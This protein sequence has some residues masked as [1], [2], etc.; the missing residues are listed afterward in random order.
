MPITIDPEFIQLLPM[1]T[2]EELETLEKSLL[3]EG[4]RDP[5]I[6]TSQGTVIDG[7]TRFV[8]C[9]KRGIPFETVV[10]DFLNRKA[11]RLWIL[12]NQ[13]GRRNLT[14]AQRISIA[15][16]YLSEGTCAPGVKEVAQKA[17][18]SER[19][20]KNF[21]KA[22]ASPVKELGRMMKDG[23]VAIRTAAEVASLPRQKQE[24]I[25]I[26]G[27]SAVKAAAAKVREGKV[28]PPSADSPYPDSS[29]VDEAISAVAKLKS[30][31]TQLLGD[32]GNDREGEQCG[33]H[34]RN[35]RQEWPK[36]LDA[37]RFVLKHYRPYAVCPYCE[38]KAKGCD[39]CKNIGWVGQS[40]FER[41]PKDYQERTKASIEK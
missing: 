25:I 19:T 35:N 1:S 12:E 4:C 8:I 10:K 20:V 14:D 27:A 11:A 40:T 41:S 32:V 38:G 26:R 15:D 36:Q 23:E 30:I 16:K 29:L 21:R 18:V 33:F 17:S 28:E 22:E 31:L 37:M 7:M 34:M 24:R 9:Q 6:V 2:K 13:L 39:G 3:A 5:L